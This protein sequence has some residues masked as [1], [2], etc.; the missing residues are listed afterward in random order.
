ME[1]GAL[2]YMGSGMGKR[3]VRSRK[4]VLSI[5]TDKGSFTETWVVF[6]VTDANAENIGT[7]LEKIP[8][9]RKRAQFQN[10]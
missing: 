6:I 5:Y 1:R 4:K 8:T 9:K 7:V 3:H 10:N 2:A